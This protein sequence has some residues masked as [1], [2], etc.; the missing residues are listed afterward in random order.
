[1]IVLRQFPPAFGLPNLSPFCMKV[2]TYLRMIG[3]SFEIRTVLDPRKAP[4]GKLP[5]VEDGTHTI[6]DSELI[7]R[8]LVRTRGDPLGDE[9]LSPADAALGHAVR[10]L[11]EEALYFPTLYS[12]WVDP[13]GWEALRA[14]VF[15]TLPPILR[16]I[17]PPLARRGV[18]RQL[19]EQGTGRH[20]RAEIYAMGVADLQALADL[21]GDRKYFVDDRPT[22]VDATVYSF[23]AGHVFSPLENPLRDKAR[24]SPNLVAYCE[25]MKAA[26]YREEG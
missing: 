21:L 16:S 19:H 20:E 18:V 11:C 9:R 13:P 10:R 26:Y 5:F 7:V 2:E 15:S 25:R 4:R 24:D 6:C 17:I 14:E 8:H 1:M 12:R 3:E 23:L 22:A